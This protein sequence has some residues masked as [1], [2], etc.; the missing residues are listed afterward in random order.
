MSRRSGLPE[1]VQE[2]H[3][4]KCASRDGGR[5]NCQRSYRASVYDPRT[6]RNRYS[7]WKR[8]RGAVE[9]WL[10][11][12]KRELGAELQG[13]ATPAGDTPVLR[14]EWAAW[15]AAARTGAISNR[16]G[17]RYKPEAVAGYD[18]HFRNHVEPVFGG[19][20][21]GT[22]TRRELQDWVDK[23]A[24]EGVP[25]STI[26]NALDPLRVLFRRALRRSV[27]AT[28]PTVDLE[29]PAKAEEEMRFA[30][31]EEAASLI[32]ALPSGER[33]LWATAFYS[34]L[35]RGELRALRWKHVDLDAAM[36][37][38]LRAW[39]DDDETGPKTRAGRRRV[40]IV[41]PLAELLREHQRLTGRS[42]ED[43]VFGRTATAP[44][45]PTTVRHRALR[46]WKAQNPPLEPITLHQCRH[47]AASFLIASKAN[48]KALSSIMG[49]ASIEITFNRYGHLMPGSEEEVGQQL[50]TYLARGNEIGTAD[51]PASGSERP[52]AVVGP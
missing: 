34:G 48:A 20:R 39:T 22:I 26:N 29:L 2:R 6:K 14:E 36:I 28:N 50:A 33:A 9:K 45:E 16:K 25:H 44:F 51:T 10:A 27:V 4:E 17:R 23:R 3:Q 7:G 38:V 21:V 46:A 8:D 12:S 32:E 49:H 35:R 13:G 30:T 40:P 15:I 19:R 42:G 11:Q 41:P 52:T 37:V 47:T 18:R 1:G 5:C 43:L 31:R 24:A